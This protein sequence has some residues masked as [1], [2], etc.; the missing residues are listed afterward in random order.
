MYNSFAGYSKTRNNRRQKERQR[1]HPDD[2][3]ENEA[4][5]KSS[6]KT[7]LLRGII[8]IVYLLLGALAF[9]HLE[10]RTGETPFQMRLKAKKMEL[11]RTF[12]VTWGVLE[13]LEELYKSG[14]R[15]LH[16]DHSDWDYYQSLYFASTVTT[17]IGR[18]F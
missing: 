13:E 6:V 18:V 9:S 12:N 10:H 3:D 8:I 15:E 16:K 2:V 17:T 11:K 4:P 1:N 7:L 5:I 14:S